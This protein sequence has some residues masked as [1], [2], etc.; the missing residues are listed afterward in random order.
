LLKQK[1]NKK[2][3]QG[4]QA[5]SVGEFNWKKKRNNKRREIRKTN[6]KKRGNEWKYLQKGKIKA[7]N[8]ARSYSKID[9]SIEEGGKWGLRD[10]YSTIKKN[11]PVQLIF[12]KDLIRDVCSCLI[13]KQYLKIAYS[14]KIA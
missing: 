13:S 8:W 3:P 11:L 14:C 1:T 2:R 12:L 5:V 7:K 9:V 6:E 4:K 10:N